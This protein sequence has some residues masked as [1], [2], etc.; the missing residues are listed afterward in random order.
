[1]AFYAPCITLQQQKWRKKQQLIALAF[2]GFCGELAQL[3]FPLPLVVSLKLNNLTFKNAMWN[4]KCSV[5]GF[6]VNLFPINTKNKR[7]SRRR[8]QTTQAKTNQSI[9]RPDESREKD[10]VSNCSVGVGA[11]Q[12][13]LMATPYLLFHCVALLLQS[14]S[15]Q[16]Y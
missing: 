2:D 14:G 6:S 7:L 1:M 10:S 5:K 12:N 11:V 16:Q 8:R 3:G 13:D 15:F 9:A 4:V